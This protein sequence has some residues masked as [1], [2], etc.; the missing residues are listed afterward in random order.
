MSISADLQTKDLQHKLEILSSGLGG[1]FQELLQGVGDE[2]SQQ[3]KQ[4]APVRSGRLRDSIKFLF[5]KKDNIGALTTRKTLN[6]STIWYG[7]QVE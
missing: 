6:K 4:N 5:D 1:I 2:M 3:A 7:R